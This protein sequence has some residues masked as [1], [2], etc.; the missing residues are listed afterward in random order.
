[1]SEKNYKIIVSD[2]VYIKM[3]KQYDYIVSK[4]GI[5]SG[6][7]WFNGIMSAISSLAI[8][9]NRCAIAAENTHIKKGSK[10]L[11]RHLIYSRSR[12]NLPLINNY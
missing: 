6:K 7:K 4:Y 12:N 2:S 11:L 5:L 3:E 8:L 10:K 9:P 1:M